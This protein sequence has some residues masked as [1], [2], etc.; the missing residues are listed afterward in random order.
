MIESVLK[1]GQE[2][3]GEEFGKLAAQFFALGDCLLDDVDCQL[4]EA[5]FPL[6]ASTIA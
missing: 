2:G 5:D 1:L 3:R 6:T 4:G